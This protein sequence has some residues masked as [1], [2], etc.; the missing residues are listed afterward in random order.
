MKNELKS[1]LLGNLGEKETEEIDLRI[2]SGS[3]L[4]EELRLAED[5]LME[6]YLDG[7]LSPSESE[8]FTN[9]FL[10]SDIRKSH[11]KVLSLLKSHAPK[12]SEN[13]S[14][15]R[16]LLSPSPVSFF[17]RLKDFFRLTPVP[18]LAVFAFA[19]LGL[20]VVLFVYN[21]ADNELA[22]LNKK[23]LSS[24]S[25]YENFYSVSLTPGTLRGAGEANNL[26]TEKMSDPVLFRLLLPIEINTENRFTAKI[27]D[28]QTSIAALTE[29]S[30]YKNQNGRELRLLLP[31]SLLKK[32]SYRIEVSGENA[33]YSPLIY[34]FTVK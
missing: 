22:E 17:Q 28:D 25:E 7:A 20:A 4:E 19:I 34:T 30:S 33:N 27:V 21:Q 14:R 9:N 23:N 32:G 18:I 6:D 1:Y 29:I 3:L 26:S 8:M 2:L 16:T 10:V 5:N 31:A 15:P 12:R 11:L 13:E 24:L